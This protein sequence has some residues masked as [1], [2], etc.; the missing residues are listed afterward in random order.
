MLPQSNAVPRPHDL[1]EC[2]IVV[3][4]QEDGRF[5]RNDQILFYGEGPDLH[6]YNVNR[7]IFLYEN[8]LYSDYSYYFLTI[9]PDEGKR[10]MSSENV[11]GDFP[12]IKTFNAFSYYENDAV[13][14]ERSGREWYGEKFG[15]QSSYTLTYDLPGITPGSEIKIVS[16]VMAQSHTDVTFNLSLNNVAI[17]EQK[18]AAVPNARYAVKGLHNRDTIVIAADEVMAPSRNAQEIRY[19]FI[20]GTGFSNGYLNYVLL[21]FIRNLA[22]YGNQTSFV[23]AASLQY[24]HCTFEVAAAPGDLRI[25]DITDHYNVRDQAFTYSDGRAVFSTATAE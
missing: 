3:T 20:K 25:W 13:N 16:D 1:V 21:T 9:G 5:D 10:I 14:L 18:I 17:G 4:G 15:T 19:E 7:Q 8:N 23:S 24:S 2:A 11:A 12:V 6:A 22:L